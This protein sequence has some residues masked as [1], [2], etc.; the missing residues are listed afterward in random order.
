MKL[1]VVVDKLLV[2]FDAPPCTY[3]YI[4]KNMQD[5]GLFQAICRVN[6]LDSDDKEFGY[7]VDYKDLF[8]K[9]ENAVAVYTSE[10]DY[11][12]FQKEDVDVL[13][14]DRLETGKERLDN[15][16]EEIAL[17]CEP[18]EP[19][20]NSLAYIRYFCG[21]PENEEDLKA[22]EA[23][24]TAL[25]K[26]TVSLIRAYSNIAAEMAEAGYSAQEIEYIKKR[27]NFHLNLREEIRMASGETLDLK[28]YEADMR[29]LIDNFIQADVPRKISPFDNQTLID[30]IVKSGIADAINSL[31][32][33]I[34]RDE[35][36]VAETIENNIRVKII[37]E[38]LIDPAYFEKMSKLLSEIIKERKAKAVNYEEYLKKMA[39]LA[40]RVSNLNRDDLPASIQTPA[41]RALYNNLDENEKVAIAVDEAIKRVKKADWR[42][43]PFKEK[44]IK[45][46]IYGILK[47]ENEVERIFPIIKQQNDY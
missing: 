11:D 32:G 40:E 15:A 39:E 9:V 42:G 46:G 13:L 21:N 5:H 1:L 31:S 27:L 4:D 8:R 36:A 6:R 23:K 14:K 47:D 25:Y 16:L 37:K 24:R 44:E 38:H 45:A 43:N 22:N 2:G 30:L 7:I 34:K 3:L 41:Q 19:P 12:D 10:L 29:H 17:L 20:K 18:V 28:A 33:G 26:H 35:K